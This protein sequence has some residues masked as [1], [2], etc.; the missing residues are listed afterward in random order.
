MPLDA[1]E[2]PSIAHVLTEALPY[3]QRYRDKVIVIKFG[4]N[5]MTDE[6]LKQIFARDIVLMKLVGIH[7]IV[8]HAVDKF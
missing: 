6:G 5:A 4:G 8:V 1:T 7:P 2:A 3:I